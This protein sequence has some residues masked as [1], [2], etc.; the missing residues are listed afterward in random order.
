[1]EGLGGGNY[2]SRKL[3]PPPIR[4]D[5]NGNRAT[6]TT[7]FGKIRYWYDKENRL[8]HSGSDA[9]RG[10]DYIYDKNGNL[11]E[12]KNLYKTDFYSYTG[13]NRMRSSVIEDHKEKTK[14]ITRYDYDALGRRTLVQDEGS[15]LMRT[16][17]DGMSF[18]II[19]EQESFADGYFT[20][21]SDTYVDWQASGEESA[22]RYRYIGEE[23]GSSSGNS[24]QAGSQG[25]NSG[26]ANSSSGN[27][28][29]GEVQTNSQSL[30][31]GN[32]HANSNAD[33]RLVSP[34]RSRSSVT[35]FAKGEAVA[36]NKN[37]YSTSA[38]S[39][40]TGNRSGTTS[41]ST[42]R[43]YF[44]TDMMGSVRSASHDDGLN[45]NY[46]DY[47]VFGKPFGETSDYGYV[48][49]PYDP[50]TG[51]SNYGYRD[52]S[53]KTARFTT[54]DPIRDGHNWYAYCSNDPINFVD[55]WGLSAGDVKLAFDIFDK[56]EINQMVKNL[57]EIQQ[58][59]LDAKMYQPGAGGNYNLPE[60]WKT[61]CNQATYD[62]A[63]STGF[64][65]SV[66]YNSEGRY[67][68]GAADATNNLAK[69]AKDEKSNILQVSPSIAQN[70]A[71]E[72]ITVIGALTGSNHLATVA[73]SS[74]KYDP[75]TGP[76]IS[77]VGAE[78][79][80]MTT[81]DGFGIKA[82]ENE[83]VVFYVDIKQKASYNAS[84]A[85]DM[86]AE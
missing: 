8:T 3:V 11:I 14:T 61:W 6:K 35:L 75:S 31:P 53:P 5:A 49:K 13:S 74:E 67:N 77:N 50:V 39:T 33:Y 80:I 86:T 69:A 82:W 27:S 46:Y 63:E 9:G 66:M 25:Q 32:F 10:T 4:H 56:N 41:A 52:Y 44:G 70:L 15:T 37:S 12:K 20:N 19:R 60:D 17:Y 30:I 38:T 34:N 24:G 83:K 73:P 79:G 51:L 78:V 85:K 55:L 65:A 23:A 43:S 29:N 68:T 47:D 48:G 72:G 57:T 18:D 71:N 54:V 81:A 28:S 2:A 42:K 58:L 76:K 40:S 84:F 1:M 26:Q 36:T 59:T 22:S 7:S 21:T 16:L 64:N 62:V 45:A